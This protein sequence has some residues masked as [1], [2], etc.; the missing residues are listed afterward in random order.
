MQFGQHSTTENLTSNTIRGISST[1]HSA[2]GKPDRNF[3]KDIG[4]VSSS[5]STLSTSKSTPILHSTAAQSSSNLH[6]YPSKH[7]LN[8]TKNNSFS[9]DSRKSL[10]EN[11]LKKMR[12]NSFNNE[13][14]SSGKKRYNKKS[15]D[16]G[17]PNANPGLRNLSSSSSYS[18]TTLTSSSTSP[19]LE[20][21]SLGSSNK[22][23]RMPPSFHSSNYKKMNRSSTSP[24]PSKSIP[25]NANFTQ[26]PLRSSSSTL[27]T[28]ENSKK[29]TTLSSKL[30]NTNSS[31]SRRRRR[32]SLL[33][34]LQGNVIFA[35]KIARSMTFSTASSSFKSARSTS[36]H[37]LS[38]LDDIELFGSVA[39][40]KR[41]SRSQGSPSP[42][43]RSSHKTSADPLPTSILNTEV[44]NN[45]PL[46]SSKA[47]LEKE[48]SS[49]NV[50]DAQPTSFHG[51]STSQSWMTVPSASVKETSDPSSL[52]FST[53]PSTVHPH[54]V[55]A[56]PSSLPTQSATHPP[57]VAQG[58]STP[59]SG[60]VSES[61]TVTPS[62]SHPPLS[63]PS[64]V[65]QGSV[66]S[67]PSH[68]AH[69][70]PPLP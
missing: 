39:L 57:S 41:R 21:S 63:S 24:S 45:P 27:S 44:K 12:S 40:I 23:N 31:T 59:Q 47:D 10:P 19:L 70:P 37:S 51:S 67:N 62:S 3:N 7:S 48:V 38:D 15:P 60:G 54:A 55:V 52:T 42:S 28:S 17:G 50:T 49:T 56:P 34:T 64:H 18:S 46:L 43:S 53:S 61:I 16:R 9:S 6:H 22:E 66:S 4:Q 68:A 20:P 29:Y 32:L 11:Q 13:N 69:H 14:T 33:D 36:P 25:S 35:K 5:S 1:T 8:Q 65:Q 26:E 2:N 58:Q 30:P